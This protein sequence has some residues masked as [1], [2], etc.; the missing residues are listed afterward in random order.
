MDRARFVRDVYNRAIEKHQIKH[1]RTKLPIRFR[2]L[3]ID[4]RTWRSTYMQRGVIPYPEN[5]VFARIDNLSTVITETFRDIDAGDTKSI[6]TNLLK[7]MSNIAAMEANVY[8]C[9]AT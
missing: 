5:V 7:Y 3:L 9:N 8:V 1:P 4:D 6:E 2:V